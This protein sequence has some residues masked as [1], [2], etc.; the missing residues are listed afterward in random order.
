M[1]SISSRKLWKYMFS[2]AILA[3][4]VLAAGCS[5]DDDPTE[6]TNV[7][8]PPSGL[9]AINGEADILLDWT[10]STD[11]G[12][13]DF[14]GYNVYRHTASLLTMTQAQLAAYKLGPDGDDPTVA[15]VTDEYVD[16]T[17]TR[18]TRYFYLVRA[19][20]D[21]GTTSASSNQIDTATR[22]EG[23]EEVA[24][25]E[26]ASDEASGLSLREAAAYEMSSSGPDNRSF[27]DVYLGTSD[28]ND[29][30]DEPLTLK[31]PHLVPDNT[32]EWAGREAQ[33]YLLGDE[34]TDPTIGDEFQVPAVG[35]T[36]WDDQV[37][38]G[39]TAQEVVGKVIAVYTPPDSE[40]DEPHYGKII[41]T[42]VS[43]SAGNRE[44]TVDVM[45]QPIDDYPRFR[46]AR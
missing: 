22:D 5:D 11:E 8:S 42:G 34:D 33:L 17:P 27:I 6:P 31:S 40:D 21:N 18:G 14:A 26:Y 46:A 39:T 36:G 3:A 15:G 45:W 23:A 20:R 35:S 37:T 9:Y 28:P 7:F 41:V 2:M 44:I 1:R 24:L 4:F 43:G 19:V 32:A 29:A 10:G 13:D 30:S 16:I 25:A 12:D 38:L